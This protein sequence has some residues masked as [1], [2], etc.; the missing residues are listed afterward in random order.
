[1][2]RGIRRACFVLLFHVSYPFAFT[3]LGECMPIIVLSIVSSLSPIL[4]GVDDFIS[5]VTINI[6]MAVTPDGRRAVSGS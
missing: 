4:Y 3:D 6:L 1:M 2:G 5:G